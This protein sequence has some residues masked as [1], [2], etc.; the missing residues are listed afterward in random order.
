MTVVE[1]SSSCSCRGSRS[2]NINSVSNDRLSSGSGGKNGELINSCY[3]W[4]LPGF[5]G[6]CLSL[7]ILICAAVDTVV[8]CVEIVPKCSSVMCFR[9]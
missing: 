6:H 1:V 4:L 3:G 5:I 2:G 8:A 9:F 7:G